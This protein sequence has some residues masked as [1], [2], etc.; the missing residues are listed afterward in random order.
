[1]R[2]ASLTP[3]SSEHVLPTHSPLAAAPTKH[4][5]F[6]ITRT[7]GGGVAF[8]DVQT[9]SMTSNVTDT[10]AAAGSRAGGATGAPDAFTPFDLTEIQTEVQADAAPPTEAAPGGAASPAKRSWAGGWGKVA[11]DRR[12]DRGAPP[13]DADAEDTGAAGPDPDPE[14]EA[15]PESGGAFLVASPRRVRDVVERAAA[16]APPPPRRLAGGAK[17][18]AD[19]G[20][21]DPVPPPGREST[22]TRVQRLWDEH[23]A[24]ES[25]ALE[26]RRSA[27]E[28]PQGA[29]LRSESIL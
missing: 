8:L 26:R 10:Q 14:S 4:G 18:T 24:S 16:M 19:P 23:E 20:A 15:A 9:P 1:M 17:D 7:I 3:T 2:T 5:V 21:D 12:G 29:R 28:R 6:G 25:A 27:R 22:G 11:S 13:T